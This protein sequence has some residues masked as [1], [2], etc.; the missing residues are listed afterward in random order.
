MYIIQVLERLETF[1]KITIKRTLKVC[2]TIVLES[3]FNLKSVFEK[4]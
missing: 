3:A 2:L 1:Y 4:N